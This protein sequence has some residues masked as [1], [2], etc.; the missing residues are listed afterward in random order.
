VCDLPRLR[1]LPQPA[2]DVRAVDGDVDDRAA[3]GAHEVPVLF[4]VGV[5]PAHPPEHALAQLA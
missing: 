4:Q 5:E 1:P 3:L 2:H